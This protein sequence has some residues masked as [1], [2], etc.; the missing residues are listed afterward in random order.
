MI[1]CSKGPHTTS[2]PQW[3]TESVQSSCQTTGKLTCTFA[4]CDKSFYFQ[5]FS[6][7]L[8]LA[9]FVLKAYL[10]TW[11]LQHH[12]RSSSQLQLRLCSSLR[13][14]FPLQNHLHRKERRF[15]RG[16]DLSPQRYLRRLQPPASARR[17]GAVR[18]WWLPSS[19]LAGCLTPPP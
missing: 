10:L 17:N 19:R 12:H 15:L 9:V 4:L 16:H 13:W 8:L 18:H 14:V 2:S 7:F 6:H 11:Q 3:A 5:G 1:I